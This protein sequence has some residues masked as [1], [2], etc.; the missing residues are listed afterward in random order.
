MLVLGGGGYTMRN[1]ARCWAYETGRLKVA[2]PLRIITCCYLSFVSLD[3]A[4]HTF[5]VV[6]VLT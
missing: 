5:I 4:V 1:V 2:F 6:P 3:C